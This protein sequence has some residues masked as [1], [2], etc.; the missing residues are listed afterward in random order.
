MKTTKG[1]DLPKYPVEFTVNGD[2]V[3]IIV[4]A[5]RTLLDVLRNDL[6]LLGTKYGCG[7]GDC[8]A[9]TVLVD[10]RPMLSCLVLAVNVLGKRVTTIEGLSKSGELSLIQQAFIDKGAIQC[11]FCTPGL[12]LVTKALLKEDPNPSEGY[13]REYIRGNLCR[14]T[15][16]VKVVEAIGEAAR[17]VGKR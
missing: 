11:G 3:R 15:G 12:V 1:I 4:P 5:N 9:C 7:A 10:D 16:Y 8:G 17:R 6:Q 13:I 2:P 14:C